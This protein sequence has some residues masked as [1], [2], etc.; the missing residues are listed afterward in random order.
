M[1]FCREGE[2]DDSNEKD[3]L[4]TSSSASFAVIM[5]EI[6]GAMST[7]SG[8]DGADASSFCHSEIVLPVGCSLGLVKVP[9]Q[10]EEAYS[11]KN[12]GRGSLALSF[13]FGCANICTG[14][15]PCDPSSCDRCFAV[16][17]VLGC[18]ARNV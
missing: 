14:T 4:F 3:K 10:A 5:A 9:T 11:S 7:S 8:F 15:T 6:A 13:A 1:D 12:L 2:I 16:N 18:V 17:S